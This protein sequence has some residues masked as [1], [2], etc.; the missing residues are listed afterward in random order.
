MPLSKQTLCTM[1]PK[2]LRATCL[3]PNYSLRYQLWVSFGSVSTIAF[4]VI[5]STSIAVSIVAGRLVQSQAESTLR[6]QVIRTVGIVS[7]SLAD[8]LSRGSDNAHGALSILVEVTRDRIV[9][10]NWETD[11]LVPFVDMISGKRRYPLAPVELPPDWNITANVDE[12][13]YRE[14]VQENRKFWYTETPISSM[15]ATFRFQGQCDPAATEGDKAYY[16]N[17]TD[18]NNNPSTGGVVQPVNSTLHEKVGFLQYVLK[19]LYESHTSIQTVGVYFFNEGAGA[20]VTYP[21]FVRDGSSSY[22]SEGCDWMINNTNPRTGQPFATPAQVARC[23]KEGDRVPGREYNALERGWCRDQALAG[24]RSVVAGPYL[25]AF[26]Q[27]LWL[28]TFGQA[29]FD[30]VTG[31]FIGCTLADISISHINDVLIGMA[32]ENME[33]VLVR[34][35]DGEIIAGTGV[36]RTNETLSIPITS[37]GFTSKNFDELKRQ[38]YQ[39]RENQ[40]QTEHIDSDDDGNIVSAYAIPT[41]PDAFDE[42]YEPNSLILMLV[43]EAVFDSITTMDNAIQNDVVELVTISATLGTLGLLVGLGLTWLV[44]RCITKPL[45]WMEAVSKRIV[46]SELAINSEDKPS[47]RFTPKTEITELVEGFGTMIEGFSGD[48]PAHVAHDTLYEIENS[49]E[50]THALKQLYYSDEVGNETTHTPKV[51]DGP[52]ARDVEM[53]AP[54]K[55][56]RASF[57]LAA[58]ELADTD[59]SSSCEDRKKECL[60]K[61]QRWDVHRSQ[62]GMSRIHRGR[63]FHLQETAQAKRAELQKSVTRSPVIRRSPLFWWIV[64]LI[65]IPLLVTVFAITSVVSTSILLTFPDLVESAKHQSIR[66]E[67][68][69]LQVLAQSRAQ[70]AGEVLYETARDLHVYKRFAEWLLL[71]VIVRS[72]SFTTVDSGVEECKTYPDDLSCPFFADK[73]RAACDCEWNDRNGGD[74][75]SINYGECQDFDEN[76][77]WLQRSLWSCQ[78]EDADNITGVRESSSFPRIDTS[79]RNTSWWDQVAELP[80]A[81]KQSNASGYQTTYDRVRVFSALS[82][83]EFPIY[84]YAGRA[85]NRTKHL[86]TFIGFESDGMLAGFS[87]CDYSSVFF[88]HFKSSEEN[89]AAR[90]RPDLCPLGKYGFDARCREWYADGKNLGRTHIT[91]PYVFAASNAIGAS[92]TAPIKDPI[93][94]KYIGQAL[95]DFKPD[96]LVKLLSNTRVGPQGK[97][98]VIVITPTSDIFGGDTVAGPNYSL[99]KSAFSVLDVVLPY[100]EEGSDFRTEFGVIVDEMKNGN[101]G[102]EFFTRTTKGGGEESLYITFAPVYIGAAETVNGSDFSRGVIENDTMVYSIAMVVPEYDLMSAFDCNFEGDL[103]TLITIFMVVSTITAIFATIVTSMVAIEITKPVMT[104]CRIVNSINDGDIQDSIPPM[105]GGSREVNQVYNSFAT[106]HKIVHFSNTAFFSGNIEWALK[107]LMD[108]LKLYHNVDDKK[109][110]GVALN[111]LGNTYLAFYLNKKSGRS[112]CT[113]HGRCVKVAA[114]E[115]YSRAIEMATI[116]YEKAVH[117][118]TINDDV[119][120]D[121]AQQLANRHF[122]RGVFLFLTEDDPCTPEGRFEVASEDLESAASLDADVRNYWIRTRQVKLNSECYFERLIRRGAGLTSSMR[123]AT[124]DIE[125][126]LHEA[127]SLLCSIGKDEQAPLIQTMSLCGR[128]QQLEEVAIRNE[129]KRGNFDDAARFAVRMLIEDDF[130]I[131]SA[132]SAAAEAILLSIEHC[133][134]MPW[135]QESIVIVKGHFRRMLKACKSSVSLPSLEK[136]IIFS[137]DANLGCNEERLHAIQNGMVTLCD[138]V[139]HLNDKF[140]LVVFSAGAA[141]NE[142]GFPLVGPTS[143]I[144]SQLINF[145]FDATSPSIGSNLSQGFQQALNMVERSETATWL[146]LVTNCQSW[147]D[148]ERWDS[149]QKE[150]LFLSREQP[151]HFLVVGI[152]LSES[153]TSTLRSICRQRDSAFIETHDNVQS[154]SEAFAEVTAIIEGSATLRGFAMEKF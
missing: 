8:T 124:A 16:P 29:I 145:S 86:G 32:Q 148:R 33:V 84:N 142:A 127:D 104:L 93:R 61:E 53:N 131:E 122:N 113:A 45:H 95:L 18:A 39:P 60:S 111:N 89:G 48:G 3:K 119:R 133:Q 80:G 154:I 37:L 28:L 10:S 78:R 59:S 129:L 2:L 138:K 82:V 42:N 12:Q 81:E 7:E 66:L 11:E 110:I 23:H 115:C 9:G 83:V 102:S 143:S 64:F 19:P 24:G 55:N 100:D 57:K 49:L 106:L 153:I 73:K 46:H 67:K 41:P 136:N 99:G 96:S 71:D 121:Y 118:E 5:T 79:P 146:V 97:G 126:L 51:D 15:Y 69:H 116:D 77:R 50:Q 72:D 63:N 123:C 141:N 6:K 103:W 151:I 125:E 75:N 14:H 92:I 134:D 98:F 90:I 70:Y 58:E 74:W 91:A 120:A 52:C 44:S 43:N 105:S 35:N 21:A 150:Y 87:G 94:N 31:D 65:V 130:L 128:L 26:H 109:A 17:C 140:G 144:A 149:V 30:R 76:P 147:M 108:A 112:C 22:V 34:W 1:A 25:D 152:D 114:Y 27:S 47:M 117:D 137:L 36:N 85:T 4:L 68:Q 56:F 107:F 54:T 20:S 40:S 132:F 38:I 135:T 13:N 62:H 88:A 101:V 139:C